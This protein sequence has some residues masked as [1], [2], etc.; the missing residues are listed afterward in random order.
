MQQKFK[1]GMVLVLLAVII[2][3]IWYYSTGW[4]ST[5][6]NEFE[7]YR[8][9][10]KW[11]QA[12]YSGIDYEGDLWWDTEVGSDVIVKCMEQGYPDT[13]PTYEGMINNDFDGW[14]VKIKE[15]FYIVAQWGE[16]TVNESEYNKI[17]SDGIVEAEFHH[18]SFWGYTSNK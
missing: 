12:N 18:G 2:K 5:T 1:I 14:E 11:V 8:T 7:Q 10:S 3:V 17:R 16:G 6:V 4:E 15:T 13:P 9:A